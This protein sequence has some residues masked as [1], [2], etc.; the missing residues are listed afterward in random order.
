M[1]SHTTHTKRRLSRILLYNQHIMST[2]RRLRMHR[3][4]RPSCLPEEKIRWSMR[5][6]S[7]RSPAAPQ[8]RGRRTG[9]AIQRSSPCARRQNAAPDKALKA[10]HPSE[11]ARNRLGCRAAALQCPHHRQGPSLVDFGQTIQDAHGPCRAAVTMEPARAGAPSFVRLQRVCIHD[12]RRH[13]ILRLFEG[14]GQAR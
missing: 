10:P 4:P 3:Y 6:D 8:S 1:G 12:N 7:C 9:R 5:S 13:A 14:E 11:K 2:S